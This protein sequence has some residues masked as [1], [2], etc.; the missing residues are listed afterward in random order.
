MIK[1]KLKND[2]YNSPSVDL[3][4]NK[5]KSFIVSVIQLL[6]HIQENSIKKL[7][8]DVFSICILKI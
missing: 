6:I 8:I 1:L 5:R 3:I 4:C 2:L 7:G